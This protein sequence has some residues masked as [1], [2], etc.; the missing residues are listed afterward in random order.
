M[1]PG[2]FPLASA[3]DRVPVAMAVPEVT[4]E[5]RG[6]V[7]TPDSVAEAMCRWAIR[8][9]TANMLDPAAG[10]G[11]FLRAARRRLAALGASGT[12]C[13]GIDIDPEAAEQ[14]GAL[15]ADF[16]GWH[17]NTDRAFDAVLG[18]PPYVRSHRFPETSRRL[19]FTGM[20]ALGMRPSRLMSTWAPFV[21]LAAAHVRP[22]GRLGLVVPEELLTIAYAKELRHQLQRRFRALTICTPPRR[23]FAS[24]QQATVL[25]LADDAPSCEPGLRVLDYHDLC[26][27]RYDA[28]QPAPTWPWTPK[29]THLLLPDRE[30][31]Q[32][33][34]FMARVRWRSLAAYGRVEVGIV[35][36]NNGY[37]LLDR[38]RADGIRHENRIPVVS[39]THQVPGTFFRRDEF[40]ELVGQ[41]APMQMLN[42]QCPP[43][44]LDRGESDYVERGIADGVSGGYKCRNRS[45]WYAVPSV[46]K[47]DAI[48][49]RQS[50]RFPRIVHLERPCAVTDTMHRIRWR[51]RVCG[52]RVAT[53]FLNVWTLLCAEL[54]GRSYGGGVLELMPSEARNLPVPEPGPAFGDLADRVDAMV[55]NRQFEDVLGVVS[56]AALPESTPAERE[57][58]GAILVRLGARR[59]GHAPGNGGSGV[60]RERRSRRLDATRPSASPQ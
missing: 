8:S 45:P 60:R 22:G 40:D 55:R 1:H 25:L 44:D 20:R 47:S 51:E 48:L 58:L 10:D 49:F 24:V 43:S 11:V 26:R 14:S 15:H 17:A 7:Y 21:A 19:A 41:D 3:S 31:R 53:G 13:F 18:N 30:R 2:L 32:V 38:R 34:E 12:D 52:R 37:F 4:Q 5:Q 46:R 29:W 57:E 42:L 23:L 9:P 16:F 54:F 36:G 35:T 50:G 56:E 59:N 28:A 39:R 6:A 27:G 33:E